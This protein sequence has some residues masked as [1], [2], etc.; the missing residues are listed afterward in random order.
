RRI[1]SLSLIDDGPQVRITF[2]DGSTATE[3]FI[4]SHPALEQGGAKLVEQLGLEMTPA[5]DILV[6]PPTQETSVKGV[7]AA[8]DAAAP[9]KSVVSAMYTGSFAGT[10]MVMQ[11]QREMEEKDEL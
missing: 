3:G 9:M 7:F 4:A 8:G 10:G 11:L 5:G 6:P 2:T 1:S